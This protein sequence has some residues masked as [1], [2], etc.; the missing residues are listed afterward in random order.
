MAHRAERRDARRLSRGGPQSLTL[1]LV[2][3]GL[4]DAF[5]DARQPVLEGEGHLRLVQQL[6]TACKTKGGEI[7]THAGIQK[8]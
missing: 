7:R 1:K 4:M 6:G 3:H 2:M 8:K 5:S